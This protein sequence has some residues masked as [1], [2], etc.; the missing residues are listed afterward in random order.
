M[1]TLSTFGK[2]CKI[3]LLDFIHVRHCLPS[4][5]ALSPLLKG[6]PFVTR[7][8]DLFFTASKSAPCHLDR[9]T[10]SRSPTAELVDPLQGNTFIF[11]NLQNRTGSNLGSQ[12]LITW[13]VLPVLLISPRGVNALFNPPLRS[14]DVHRGC[15]PMLGSTRRLQLTFKRTFLSLYLAVRHSTTLQQLALTSSLGFSLARSRCPISR[16]S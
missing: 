3:R 12:K 9:S 8:N 13:T 5:P 11:G 7:I 4:D 15:S 10:C 14:Q 2:M 16:H 6:N 1:N